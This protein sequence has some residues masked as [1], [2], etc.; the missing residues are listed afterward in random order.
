M[1]EARI[2]NPK[3]ALRYAT[4]KGLKVGISSNRIPMIEIEHPE[5]VYC[6]Y[7]LR[8][9]AKVVYGLDVDEACNKVVNEIARFVAAQV[10]MA[11]LENR[12]RRMWI[13]GGRAIAPFYI[14]AGNKS[15]HVIGI[16]RFGVDEFRKL[17]MLYQTEA[18][19]IDK[20][21]IDMVLYK[22][23]ATLR[24][25][26]KEKGG[27]VKPVAMYYLEEILP[28]KFALTQHKCDRGVRNFV[29]KVLNVMQEL[30]KVSVD[31]CV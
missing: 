12:V 15:V 17:Y 10:A 29:N 31:W 5:I 11:S 18:R 14:G 23:Y 22:G 9:P 24:V 3:G 13:R 30:L 25:T 28:G 21:Y 2:R 16:F 7:W 27:P 6:V 20:R 1:S 19:Y 26:A 4:Q 8:S